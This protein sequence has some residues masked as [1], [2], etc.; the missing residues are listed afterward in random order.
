MSEAAHLR[1]CRGCSA[2]SLMWSGHC[3]SR[4][5]LRGELPHKRL[6]AVLKEFSDSY[7]TDEANSDIGIFVF[8]NRL[9]ASVILH[10]VRYSMAEVPTVLLKV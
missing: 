2:V 10:R 3:E 1:L 8:L 4:T 5:Y 7:P 6:K 9:I